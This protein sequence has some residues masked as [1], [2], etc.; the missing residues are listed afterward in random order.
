LETTE[1]GAFTGLT[2]LAD[3]SISGNEIS[4]ITP[5][6]F[7][8]MNRLEYLD[9]EGNGIENLEV[10]VFLGLINLKVVRLK[11]NKLQYLHPDTFVGLPIFKYL[12]L[13]QNPDLQIP[14]DRHFVSSHSLSHLDI[15]GCNVSSM[16]VETFA[17]VTA[18]ELLDLSYNN[19]S[20]V[21]I[22]ILKALPKLSALYLYANPLQC[23]CQLQDVWQW[24]Q[25]HNIQSVSGETAPE[26]ATP[27]EVE[28][29]WWGVLEKGQCLQDNIY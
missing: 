15:S 23:D 26:C 25:D 14:T 5:R 7:E 28:G 21:D 27:S 24:C 17:N 10:D 9:L 13:S 22:N 20:S 2:K 6:T 1:F 3:L 29:M 16:S 18:L 8:K 4:E 12:T 19:L 11:G